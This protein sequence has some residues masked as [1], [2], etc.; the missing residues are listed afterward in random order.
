VPED[1]DLI[2]RA[3]AAFWEPQCPTYSEEPSSN[4][5]ANE[6]GEATDNVVF[7]DL[8]HNAM[9]TMTAAGNEPVSLFNA[10]LE[11]ITKEIDEFYSLCEEMDVRPLPLEDSWVMVDGSNF[12]VPSSPQPPPP[13]ATTNNAADTSSAPVDGSRA[14]S[15]MAYLSC[16]DEAVAV[17]VVEN[18]QKLLKKVVAGG[19]AWTNCGGGG[20]TGTAQE[21]SGI[22]NHVMSERKRREKINE[23]FLIL[24]SLVPSIHKAMKIYAINFFILP[25]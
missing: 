3:T 4:P 18:P 23:M 2:S 1:P 12:E 16:S 8:G 13:G 6:A 14:T 11:H 7:E 25:C 22:K 9:E 10:S 5:S 15:F 21:I 24:K 19:G 17:P 20:T